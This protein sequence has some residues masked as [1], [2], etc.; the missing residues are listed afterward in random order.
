[1]KPTHLLRTLLSAFLALCFILT[2]TAQSTKSDLILKGKI[3][4][5]DNNSYILVPFQVPSGVERLTVEFSY[6]G[7]SEKTTIDL[8]IVGPGRFDS[9]SGFRG[10][11]GGNKTSFTLSATD[12]TPSYLPGP[13]TEGE[14]NLVLG[15]PNI[16]TQSHAT[17]EAKVYFSKSDSVYDYPSL[18]N[19]P[20]HNKAGWY[21]GDFHLHSG[22][23]DGYVLNQSGKKTP[24][25]VYLTLEAA[26]SHHLDF[27][28]LTDHNT[29]SQ[30]NAI[31][32]LQP[33]FDKLL[34]LPGYEVTTF[35]G[36][37]NILG[38][39]HLVDFR[40][41]TK[42]VPNWDA[43]LNEVQKLKGL[44]SINHPIRPS[45]ELCM[46]CGWRPTPEP[47]YNKIN[48]I[49][50]INGKDADSPFSGINFWQTKLNEGY[51]ITGIGGSDNHNIQQP[52]TDLDEKIRVGE[53]T[54]VV[55]AENLSYQSILQAISHG[56][57]FID[58]LGTAS[59]SLEFTAKNN[60]TT[61]TMGDH[62]GVKDGDILT[63]TITA[64]NVPVGSLEIIRD[65][66]RIALLQANQTTYTWMSDG[67]KHWVRVN[68]RDKNNKLLLLGNPI[69]INR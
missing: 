29:V 62:L 16:R 13:I 54:T 6:T 2:C 69:Y 14:W 41:G 42:A 63:F 25:P 36:H 24:S 48:S 44:V 31:R 55:Y 68:V 11:S 23:S 49:E 64:K 37:A 35:Q 67:K 50:V 45:G 12:A 28:F 18:L 38:L 22:H 5:K 51:C 17:Y 15:V 46:G 1:V 34:I 65:A 56:H 3:S 26:V 43:V 4:G 66:K 40:V 32:E 9:P 39:T 61:A 27:I 33:Y 53:P 59:G 58:V 52:S 10:W 30:L 60:T 21:R 8:G 7:K 47:D 20:I 19:N 57:V